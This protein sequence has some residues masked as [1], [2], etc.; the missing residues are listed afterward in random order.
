MPRG[1]AVGVI[2]ILAG[3]LDVG[4]SLGC[5]GGGSAS[6]HDAGAADHTSAPE[7]GTR[8]SGAP[9]SGAPAFVTPQCPLMPCTPAVAWALTL[10]PPVTV[11]AGSGPLPVAV[12]GPLVDGTY[13]LVDETFYGPAPLDY[14]VERPGDQVDATLSLQGGFFNELLGGGNGCGR[15][16]VPSDACTVP[17][18][19]AGDMLYIFDTRPFE[20][21]AV[22]GTYET[23]DAFQRV[24]VTARGP[25]LPA[26]SDGG[27]VP[28]T[29]EAGARDPG[30]PATAPPAGTPCNPQPP[31]LE[32]EYGGDT[33]GRC[34]TL[35]ECALQ[36]DG[37]YLFQVRPTP[38]EPNPAECPAS[39]SGASGAS[40]SAGGPVC[41]YA[42]GA[43]ACV[44]R[45]SGC[46][47]ECRARSDVSSYPP[48]SGPPCPAA[49]PLAGDPCP[50]EGE[51]CQYDSPCSPSA[52]LG[53]TMVC[54]H[55]NWSLGYFFYSCLISSTLACPMSTLRD[56]G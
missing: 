5:S 25:A 36:P 38:C 26:A 24:P 17:Y 13:Q 3:V 16:A 50:A 35:A 37:G 55:G 18:T 22:L 41:N 9:E 1:Q 28:R 48:D 14:G 32:C 7:S 43:C 8:V 52:S 33:Q 40:C 12:G 4:L 51:E 30:C 53:P 10:G 54:Q 39:F 49:R 29:L 44:S 6:P 42:E 21:D 47:W 45:S 34:T 31:P 11:A 27:D 2:A 20:G 56:G 15:L 19:A 46:G 23:V